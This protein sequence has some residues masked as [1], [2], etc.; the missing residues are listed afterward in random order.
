[1]NVWR[2]KCPN[3]KH[4]CYRVLDFEDSDL[5]VSLDL[6]D[7]WH[8]AATLITIAVSHFQN[9]EI[10]WQEIHSVGLDKYSWPFSWW[11]ALQI[12]WRQRGVQK[13][14]ELHI[15]LL[16]YIQRQVIVLKRTTSCNIT[17]IWRYQP[18][19][20]QQI[21]GFKYF[22]E[23]AQLLINCKAR[24]GKAIFCPDPPAS[25]SGPDPR[26]PRKRV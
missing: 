3:A 5:D 24:Q 7:D 15:V 1:M 25:S 11:F 18:E 17:L 19:S 4:S 6:L 20:E 14:E 16:A 9:I 23:A 21:C 26:K 8:V 12:V 22:C 2:H 13:Q 10:R